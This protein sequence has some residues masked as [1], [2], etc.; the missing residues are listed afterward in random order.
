MSNGVPLHPP[1]TVTSRETWLEVVKY[2]VENFNESDAFIV[3][4]QEEEAYSIKE[5]QSLLE[6]ELRETLCSS[7]HIL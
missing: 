6:D 3:Q 4:L 1:L 5:A 2:Y 7:M